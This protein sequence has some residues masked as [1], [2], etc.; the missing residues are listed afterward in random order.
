[1]ASIQNLKKDINYLTESVCEDCYTCSI[2]QPEVETES[3]A[4][5]ISQAIEFRNV[6]IS[7]VNKAVVKGDR[8]ATTKNFKEIQESI[9]TQVDA[10]FSSLSSLIK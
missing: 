5:I 2:I 7:R 3:I 1:M 6:M 10:M 4:K 8:K 9:L